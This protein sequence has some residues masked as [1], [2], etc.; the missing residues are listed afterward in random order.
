[1]G[2]RGNGERGATQMQRQVDLDRNP[3]SGL[4]L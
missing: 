4:L 1:M 3:G 2:R